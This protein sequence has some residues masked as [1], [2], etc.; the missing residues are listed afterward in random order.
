MQTE[1]GT[2]ILQLTGDDIRL[3]SLVNDRDLF[4][5]PIVATCAMSDMGIPL[6]PIVAHEISLHHLPNDGELL[7]MPLVAACGMIDTCASN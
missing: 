4:R 3:H 1:T 2:R 7:R 5:M 6:L